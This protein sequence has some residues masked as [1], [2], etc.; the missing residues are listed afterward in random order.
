MRKRSW[1]KIRGRKP[2]VRANAKAP[3]RVGRMAGRPGK[4]RRGR[5]ARRRKR[6][7]SRIW[8]DTVLAGE[9]KVQVNKSYKCNR[10]SII[11]RKDLQFGVL[12][13]S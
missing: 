11:K 7:V 2:K 8:L 1:K 9:R 5:L 10:M 4:A 13:G 12:E 3:R 6:W